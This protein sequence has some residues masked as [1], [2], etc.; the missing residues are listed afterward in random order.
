VSVA[1][2][3]NNMFINYEHEN[4]VYNVTTEQRDNY[5][6]ITYDN[7]EY[8]VEAEEIKPGQLKIKIGD[9]LVK[10][11]ITDGDKEKYVFVDGNIYKVK[12]VELTGKKKPKKKEEGDLSSPI[13]GKVVN[14]KAKKGSIVKKDDVLMVIEAMKMEY[15]IRAPFNGKV[16]KVNFKEND[17]IEIGQNTVELEKK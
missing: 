11:V 9:R 14:V 1:R 10:V 4:H 3:E 15:L 16:K 6:F 13:S 2:R 8:K 7:T 12:H 17:Q 5:Y